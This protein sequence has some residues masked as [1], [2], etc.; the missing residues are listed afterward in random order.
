MALL[1]S[2]VIGGRLVLKRRDDIGGFATTHEI[3]FRLTVRT[4]DEIDTT[5]GMSFSGP[6]VV[7]A[8]GINS[9]FLKV[10]LGGPST[11]TVAGRVDVHAITI[12][13]PAS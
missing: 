12:G 4:L 11:M 6:V 1:Q 8:T 7:E 13:G 3:V 9:S 10:V 2:D 5:G